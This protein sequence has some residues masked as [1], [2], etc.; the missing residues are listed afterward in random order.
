MSCLS[1]GQVRKWESE[2]VALLQHLG[3]LVVK[4]MMEIF[5]ERLGRIKSHGCMGTS[6]DHSTW[7]SVCGPHGFDR[8]C[9]P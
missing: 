6:L 5:E 8:Q 2:V 3:R 1:A 4:G 7:L 9:A